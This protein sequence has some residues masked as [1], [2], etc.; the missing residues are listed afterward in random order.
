MDLAYDINMPMIA[1]IY[2]LLDSVIN[3]NSNHVSQLQLLIQAEPE[4]ML[5]LA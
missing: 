3:A 1:V 5:S 2:Q 4:Y